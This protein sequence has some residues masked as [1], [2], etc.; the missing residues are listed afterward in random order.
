MRPPG[1]LLVLFALGLA[2]PSLIVAR[3]H[4][5]ALHGAV[6][7][8][9]HRVGSARFDGGAWTQRVCSPPNRRSRQQAQRFSASSPGTSNGTDYEPASRSVHCAIAGLW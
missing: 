1:V 3:K 2:G 6:R 9:I 4:A 7:R 5:R 8:L